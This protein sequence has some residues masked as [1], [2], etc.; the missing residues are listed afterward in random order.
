M[1]KDFLNK[2]LGELKQSTNKSKNSKILIV[3]AANTFMRNFSAVQQLNIEGYHVGGLTGF[4]KSVGY[5][6]KLYGPS[7]V[8]LV[9]DGQGN[10]T[11][12]KYLYPEYKANR[13][14]QKVTNWKIFDNKEEEKESMDNQMDRLLSYLSQMPMSL[15]SIPKIEADDTIGYLVE[16]LENNTEVDEITLMSA[17]RDFL[18]LVSDKTQVYSPTKKITYHIND[19]FNEYLVYPHNFIYYKILM[20]DSGDNVPGVSGLGPK[21]LFKLFPELSDKEKLDDTYIL[22]KA[23]NNI[24]ENQ[25][26]SKVI[27]FKNQLNIN[28]QLMSL[29]YPMIMDE[30][31]EIIDDIVL[32]PPP[33]LNVGNLLK[34]IEIDQLNDKMNWGTWLVEIFG[35]LVW[36]KNK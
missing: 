33:S 14:T 1:D 30:D 18:Q 34:M 21:K 11:N 32:N 10:S 24:K 35:S 20:G 27:E 15:I 22:K 36:I 26:Y 23:H 7:R 19:V 9:F 25:L 29:K 28:Y 31:K 8:I 4:I 17:D 2:L 13:K 6:I 16:T 3:D 12:K 5:A